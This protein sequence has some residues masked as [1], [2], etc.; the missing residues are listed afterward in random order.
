MAPIFALFVSLVIPEKVLRPFQGME[1]R[2]YQTL[3]DCQKRE[4]TGAKSCK[5]RWKKSD[6]PT[7]FQESR[8][9][10]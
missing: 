6:E 3:K 2:P 7:H 9:L 4:S 5:M 8:C 10:P 1:L